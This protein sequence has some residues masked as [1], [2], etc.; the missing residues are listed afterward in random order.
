MT[1]KQ[2]SAHFCPIILGIE[3]SCDECSVAIIDGEGRIYSH[4]ILSQ[5][6]MHKP[7]GGVVP[8]IAA[9]DH[10]QQISSLTQ[11]AFHESGVRMEDIDAV[12]ATVG[13]GLAGGLL[14]G[15]SF[16]KAFSI[17]IKK[18]F[19]P[20][21]H[22]EGHVLAIRL[23]KKVNFPYLALLISGGHCQFIVAEAVGKYR[24]YG[25][26]RDDAAGEAFDKA[27][28]LLGLDYPGGPAIEKCATSYKGTDF[29]SLPH[30]LARQ[31]GCDFSFS[32][33]KTALGQKIRHLQKNNPTLD[34]E[35]K[36]ML[37]ASF[38]NAVR[39]TLI[40]RSQHAMRRFCK[41]FLQSPSVFVLCGGVASNQTIRQSFQ[42]CC[43]KEQ[44]ELFIPPALLCT[45]NAAMIAWVGIE[46]YRLMQEKTEPDLASLKQ[47][48]LKQGIRP[49][50]S[51]EH[52]S[53]DL[54]SASLEEGNIPS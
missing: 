18:P 33:L 16:A 9:R 7:F 31:P 36:S 43:D 53:P 51:I 26:T 23:E 52:L 3:T 13:P 25:E 12:A 35:T 37:A 34:E 46:R 19:L 48:S 44:F 30:P 42:S 47:P 39:A 32:G 24:L 4:L 11:R 6:Q 27:A 1:Q 14:V 29:F 17:G 54:F 49:R 28:I 20:I 45:D 21:N 40:E 2:Q 10:L 38:Q 5:Y 22:L 15:S 50:W 41:D 8:E